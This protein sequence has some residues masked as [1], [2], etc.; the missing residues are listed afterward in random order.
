MT[1]LRLGLVRLVTALQVVFRLL[2]LALA[3]MGRGLTLAAGVLGRVL[4]A[5]LTLPAVEAA[6]APIRRLDERI[7]RSLNRVLPKRLY[8]RTLLIIILPMVLLQAVVAYIFM[9]RHW[10]NVT[11]RLSASLLPIRE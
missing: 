8:T 3:T 4:D 2:L 9:E 5:I 6:L 1:A 11:A 10:Q 7:G